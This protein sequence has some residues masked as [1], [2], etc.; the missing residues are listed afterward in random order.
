MGY[1]IAEI[2]KSKKDD[3]NILASLGKEL[4]DKISALQAAVTRFNALLTELKNIDVTLCDKIVELL[5]L[6]AE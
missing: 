3:T 4:T 2:L 1:N 5:T 6:Q